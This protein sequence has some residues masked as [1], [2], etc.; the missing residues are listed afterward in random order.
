MNSQKAKVFVSYSRADLPFPRNLQAALSDLGYETFLDLHDIA[1]GENW[2]QRLDGML[3][4][5][6]VVVFVL[7]NHWL[8][9]ETCAWELRRT[10]E[11][12]KRMAPLV[13]GP[14]ESR[15]PP[16][17]AELNWT[18]SDEL[19]PESD[20]TL[21]GSTR[22]EHPTERAL[23]GLCSNLDE[24]TA[25]LREHSR[26][27]GRALSWQ[28]DGRTDEKLLRHGEIFSAREWAQLKP[29]GSPPLPEV[30]NEFF[31]ASE[32]FE[33]AQRNRL[34]MLTQKGF[35]GPAKRAVE[36]EHYEAGLR[37]IAAAAVL[38]EDPDFERVPQ[39]RELLS[40]VDWNLTLEGTI[41]RVGWYAWID[42]RHLLYIDTEN[43]LRCLNIADWQC[44]EVAILKD[45]ENLAPVDVNSTGGE[46]VYTDL[47][48]V[49][50][51]F[52]IAAGS[53]VMLNQ[54]VSQSITAVRFLGNR[55]YALV[56]DDGAI[57]LVDRET[58][59]IQ[60]WLPAPDLPEINRVISSCDG[61]RL[62]TETHFVF[63]ETPVRIWDTESG[64]LLQS[65]TEA[66]KAD[67]D[68]TGQSVT[69]QD[70]YESFSEINAIDEDRTM[71]LS[72]E[73]G[74]FDPVFSPCGTW[75]AT[76]SRDH[77]VRLWQKS[78]GECIW[79][80][81]GSGGMPVDLCFS[82]D[83]RQLVVGDDQGAIRFY[84]MPTGVMLQEIQNP[85]V[86][87]QSVKTGRDPNL[88][89][90]RSIDGAVRIYRRAGTE[91]DRVVES[92]SSTV[93]SRLSESGGIFVRLDPENSQGITYSVLS[94]AE[95]FRFPAIAD[96][97][98]DI[99][100]SPCE[101]YL[102]VLDENGKLYLYSIPECRLLTDVSLD[103][104]QERKLHFSPG[105]SFLVVSET[106]ASHNR[107]Y[108]TDLTGGALQKVHC[109]D[110]EHHLFFETEEQI[111]V[112]NREDTG[113]VLR[114]FDTHTWEDLS[115][116]DLGFGLEV[117]SLSVSPEA[118]AVAL[119]IRDGNRY[120]LQVWS[121]Y[122][123]ERLLT[124]GEDLEASVRSIISI[125]SQSI[126]FTD[127]NGVTR[128]L[129]CQSLNCAIIDQF[130]FVGRQLVALEIPG[131]V[132]VHGSDYVNSYGEDWIRE[133][134]SAIRLLDINQGC[135][136]QSWQQD[137]GFTSMAPCAWN[138]TKIAVSTRNGGLA[139]IDFS[140]KSS[141]RAGSAE[142]LRILLSRGREQVTKQEQ[143][144]FLMSA[145]PNSLTL[146]EA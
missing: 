56:A 7:S 101:R 133:G 22:P 10:L 85:L 2:K 8:A 76:L 116:I 30:L 63:D 67:F 144:D 141:A 3:L 134:H 62:L 119:G 132:M 124:I 47:D 91:M 113:L 45:Y 68:P 103:S 24:D 77:C 126:V 74:I 128:T 139:L 130:D 97:L 1:K 58:G 5:S 88:V 23:K 33:I 66:W 21:R 86:S 40:Q 34:L 61:S 107:V 28:D 27:L 37:L 80:S 13:H 140:R 106:A 73:K 32:T 143:C 98:L 9:S 135:C 87:I 123:G 51:R 16:R 48:S 122:A 69:A 93:E 44:T 12:G 75:V 20:V 136:L 142:T 11:L 127:Q 17:L 82:I 131:L 18:F 64:E 120:S 57:A 4:E 60:R 104:K 92:L 72:H 65:I 114:R 108:S 117:H 121:L 125:D 129:D 137:D 52:T 110:G 42:H 145:A 71:L 15:P 109:I 53:K 41:P 111:L 112:V 138:D 78:D 36:L 29:S 102:A 95:L 79:Q 43:T 46:A 94:G 83:G 31:D 105:G 90:S 55:G 50:Y 115:T 118:N 89:A 146:P 19:G 26:W 25:W 96:D 6:D 59:Q 54:D 99:A 14:L 38:G 84:Q 100:I 81:D 35:W 39:F 70:A 49:I